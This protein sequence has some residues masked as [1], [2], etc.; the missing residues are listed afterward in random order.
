MVD[1]G[2]GVADTAVVVVVDADVAAVGQD[3]VAPDVL[4][5]VVVDADDTVEWPLSQV[6]VVLVLVPPVLLL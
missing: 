2:V 5:G 6:V 4:P 3:D 1:A